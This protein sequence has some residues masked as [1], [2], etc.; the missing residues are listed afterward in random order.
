MNGLT[1]IPILFVMLL[2]VCLCIP[3]VY[4]SQIHIHNPFHFNCKIHWFEHALYYELDYQYGKPLQTVLYIRWHTHKNNV[5]TNPSKN[6]CTP[7][8]SQKDSQSV[9]HT[10]EKESQQTIYEKIKT[11]K[12]D[13]P[14]STENPVIPW[15]RP[16]VLNESFIEI[17]TTYLLQVL[18]HSRMRSFYLKGS[19]GF[20]EPYETGIFAGILYAA[21]PLNIT[22][23]RFNFVEEKYDCRGYAAGRVYP[24]VLL[25][26]SINFILSK[27]VRSFLF[28]WLKKGREH[29]HG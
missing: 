3:I 15:W 9:W 6:R 25:T 20:P 8:T 17:G 2:I 4:E 7:D 5:S 27:P 13:T 22:E 11:A 29:S 24:A 14:C 10:L 21:I 16:Y 26:Y 1:I 18:R 23:L 28:H 12:K 19:L